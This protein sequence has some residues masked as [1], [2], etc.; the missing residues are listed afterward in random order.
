M[1]IKTGVKQLDVPEVGHQGMYLLL[2][3]YSKNELDEELKNT[4]FFKSPTLQ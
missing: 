4:S 1:Q 2:Y 3:L